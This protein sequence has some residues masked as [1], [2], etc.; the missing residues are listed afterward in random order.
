MNGNAL[1]PLPPGPGTIVGQRQI[2]REQAP[3]GAWPFVASVLERDSAGT[4]LVCW[5]FYGLTPGDCEEQAAAF[6]LQGTRGALDGPLCNPSC[7]PLGDCVEG[8]LGVPAGPLVWSELPPTNSSY[9]FTQGDRFAVLASVSK[10][11]TLAQVV[12]YMNT[13]G[14]DV[15]YSWEQGSPTRGQFPIDTFLANLAPDTTDNHRWI[16]GEANRVGA[17]WTKGVDAPWPLTV[18]HIADVLK[19]VPAPAG[20]ATTPPVLPT[21]S[22]SASSSGATTAVVAGGLGVGAGLLLPMAW[23][24]LRTVL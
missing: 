19:A 7:G 10:D 20:G 23:R 12:N 1:A 21:P 14:W 17:D 4:V 2:G 15:T 11:F 18:Y 16:Y 13:N 24:A 8:S 6:L 5:D 9:T 3:A 22:T